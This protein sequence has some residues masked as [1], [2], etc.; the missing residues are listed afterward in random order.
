[1]ARRTKGRSKSG[2]GRDSGAGWS[3]SEIAA[4]AKLDLERAVGLM[5]QYASALEV[6]HIPPIPFGSKRRINAIAALRRA[7][8]AAIRRHARSRLVEIARRTRRELALSEDSTRAQLAAV[9]QLEARANWSRARIREF[10]SGALKTIATTRHWALR[11]SKTTPDFFH[12]PQ[13]PN[14]IEKIWESDQTHNFGGAFVKVRKTKFNIKIGTGYNFVVLSFPDAPDVEPK[15]LSAVPA[16]QAGGIT[17]TA[18][19]TSG[20]E[21]GNPVTP[22]PSNGKAIAFWGYGKIIYASGIPAGC[23]VRF[24]QI[25]YGSCYILPSGGTTWID[26]FGGDSGKATEDPTGS[27][28]YPSVPLGTGMTGIADFPNGGF[29]PNT[30]ICTYKVRDA[31]YRTWVVLECPG[32]PLKRLGYWEWSYRLILHMGGPGIGVLGGPPKD[33]PAPPSGWPTPGAGPT[34]WVAEASASYEAK[35]DYNRLFP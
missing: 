3:A 26:V 12:L 11:F 8:V 28:E 24:K 7:E 4:R 15:I 1:M 9:R 35:G 33:A 21:T 29:S 16:V 31:K 25:K 6:G 2:S 14:F 30:A 22:A 18:L 10:A 17:I 34:N 19:D 5:V 13:F 32:A 23:K 27:T 20:V